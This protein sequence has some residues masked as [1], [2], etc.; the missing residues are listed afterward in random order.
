MLKKNSEI[1]LMLAVHSFDFQA[2]SWVPCHVDNFSWV[3]K[4]G[5]VW[6]CYAGCIIEVTNFFCIVMESR[7]LGLLRGLCFWLINKLFNLMHLFPR[8]C[9]KLYVCI[10]RIKENSIMFMLYVKAR[11]TLKYGWKCFSDFYRA[12]PWVL[13][14]SLQFFWLF[15]G[16]GFSF[17]LSRSSK[18]LLLPCSSAV[19]LPLAQS[20]SPV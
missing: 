5:A 12:K 11:S 1:L 10:I 16:F 3:R 20:D 9:C 4:G 15:F 2:F 18:S 8:L 6:L 14:S 7:E 17:F 13:H 19:T